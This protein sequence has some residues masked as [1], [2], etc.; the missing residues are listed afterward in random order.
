MWRI[1]C[2]PFM[3]QRY[4]NTYDILKC[5]ELLNKPVNIELKTDE[6]GVVV[7]ATL[8]RSKQDESL[9]QIPLDAADIINLSPLE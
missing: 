6:A 4:V 3:A 5:E 2:S 7:D 8:L 1:P 9:Q